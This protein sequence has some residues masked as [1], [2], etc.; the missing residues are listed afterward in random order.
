MHQLILTSTHSST[1]TTPLTV[2]SDSTVMQPTLDQTKPVLSPMVFLLVPTVPESILLSTLLML[3]IVDKVEKNFPVVVKCL[4][5]LNVSMESW[6]QHSTCNS[7][8]YGSTNVSYVW[9]ER[10]N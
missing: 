1:L 3:L 5:H 4:S 10:E 8:K 7:S 2:T 6:A 9:K